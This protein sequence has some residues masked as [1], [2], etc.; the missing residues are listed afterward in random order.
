MTIDPIASMTIDPIT[1]MTIGPEPIPPA[2]TPVYLTL[3][4]N[5]THAGGV[6]GLNVGDSFISEFPVIPGDCHAIVVAKFKDGSEQ[7][8]LN[9]HF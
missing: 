4:V 1:S 3:M 7:I 6:G 8:I 2:T 5:G 9:R